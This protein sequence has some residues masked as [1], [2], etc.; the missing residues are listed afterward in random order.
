MIQ[1]LHPWISTLCFQS[2]VLTKHYKGMLFKKP[3]L[4][5][6]FPEPP[7]AAL[8]QPPNL[9]SMLCKSKL[10]IIQRADKFQR[11]SHRSA[12]GWK[13]CGNGSTTCCPY[14]H[15]PTKQVTGYKHVIKD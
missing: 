10:S 5:S 14:T 9:R 15:P 11:N 7:M 12:T 2:D 8:R 4:K 6:T 1:L 3:E 13:K